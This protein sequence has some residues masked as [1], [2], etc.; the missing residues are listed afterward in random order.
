MACHM[1]WKGV[2]WLAQ[3]PQQQAQNWC[4]SKNIPLFETSAKD[5]ISV[6]HAFQR[7]AKDALA[8]EKDDIYTLV[9]TVPDIRL[10]GSALAS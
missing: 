3:V 10:D 2:M 9:Y 6:E 7:I 4:D 8:K 5:A 1:M